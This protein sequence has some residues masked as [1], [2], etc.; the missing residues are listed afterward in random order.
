MA[1]FQ[2]IAEL[3][4]IPQGGGKAFSVAGKRIAVF[5]IGDELFAIDD[6]CTHAEAS[7]AE[8]KVS[9]CQV[10]C[11]RHGAKFDLRTGSALTLPAIRPVNTYPVKLEGN[12]V[13]INLS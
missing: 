10:A 9:G 7:L 3:E 12:L 4:E 13:L 11:P 6:T 8:G 5:R 1:G 2:K